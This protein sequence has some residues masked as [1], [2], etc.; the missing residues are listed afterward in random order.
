M[1]ALI[2]QDWCTI[3]GDLSAVTVTIPQEQL[4]WLDMSPYQDVFFWLDVRQMNNGSGSILMNYE[5][6]PVE[7]DAYFV[8]VVTA[9]D[10]SS[11]HNVQRADARLNDA[12]V[13]VARF[14]R[15][16]ITATP[17]ATAWDTTFRIFVTANSPGR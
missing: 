4:A 6:S 1:D 3:G 13:A 8:P 14:L 16:K 15:W 17:T 2:L 11:V 12:I 10:M 9:F 5:T 7:D